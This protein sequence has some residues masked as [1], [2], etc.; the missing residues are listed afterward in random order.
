M[1]EG[2]ILFSGMM[3]RAILNL[4]KSMTRRTR[5]LGAINAE[6]DAWTVVAN[7]G[8]EEWLLRRVDS[9]TFVTVHCPYGTAGD[10]LW[11]RESD[12][13]VSDGGL[14]MCRRTDTDGIGYEV[15]SRD[16]SERFV[17]DDRIRTWNDW[18]KGLKELPKTVISRS[19]RKT[20]QKKGSFTVGFCDN[21][22]TKEISQT[23]PH[24]VK[25]YAA[26]FRR[27]LPSIHM[28][29]WASRITLE[30]TGVRVER[31]QDISEQDAVSEGVRG[32]EKMLAGGTDK[33]DPDS[34]YEFGL[35]SSPRFCFQNLWDWINADRP[36]LPKDVNSKRYASVKRWLEKHPP[37]AW[38]NNP[39]VWVVEFKRV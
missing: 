2:P 7:K 18:N 30:I 16:G 31:L 17:P 1:K 37:C 39:W 24:H 22:T 21:D 6:P 14:W 23:E 34:G 38:G 26:V 10:R 36:K 28:P 8:G 27:K 3:V 9:S 35:A 5:G 19:C 33:L 32:L 4:I 20:G 15:Y 29:R 11:V 12:V 25:E 13:Y